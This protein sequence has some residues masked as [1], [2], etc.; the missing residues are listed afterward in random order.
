MRSLAQASLDRGASNPATAF[1]L[2]NNISGSLQ[3]DQNLQ[4]SDIKGLINAFR[5]LDPQSI[6]MVTVPVVG[7]M[8]GDAQVVELQQPDAEA[9]LARL[10]TF[11]EPVGPAHGGRAATSARCKVLNGSGVAGRG[12]EVLNDLVA[13]GFVAAGP[14]QDADRGDYAVTR[15]ALERQRSGQGADGR[16]PTWGPTRSP[17]LAWARPV[18][19]TSS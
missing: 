3:K 12:E 2:L 19:P 1:A 13:H 10:R 5:D 4:L 15:G 9:I 11:S 14:A 7:V 18:A 16:A 17:S 8:K 6:E